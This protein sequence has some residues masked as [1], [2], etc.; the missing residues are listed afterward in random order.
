SLSEL[1]RELKTAIA[2]AAEIV[3]FFENGQEDAA[4]AHLSTL[5]DSVRIFSMIFSEDL[6]WA[7]VPNQGISRVELAAA[8]Q[9]ALPQLLAAKENGLWVFICDVIEYEISPI[10]EAWQKLVERTHAR[11]N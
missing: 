11:I 6:G 10:L 5:L 1:N 3:S 7:E 8:M 4:Y 2:S 9:R